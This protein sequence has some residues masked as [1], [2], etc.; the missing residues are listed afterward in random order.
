MQE[1][2]FMACKQR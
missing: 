1:D 2:S